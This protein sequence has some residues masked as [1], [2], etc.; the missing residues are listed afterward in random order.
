MSWRVIVTETALEGLSEAE[1]ATVTAEMFAWVDDSPPRQNR[2]PV[3]GAPLFEDQLPS[4][5]RVVYFVEESVPYVA[6]VRVRRR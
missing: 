4:G 3:C 5:F 2:R 1:K 6:V